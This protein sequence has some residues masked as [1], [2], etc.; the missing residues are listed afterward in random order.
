M[1]HH[2]NKGAGVWVERAGSGLQFSSAGGR[3][4]DRY[5]RWSGSEVKCGDR[6]RL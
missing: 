2:E 3:V 6:L 4:S 1:L 5:E